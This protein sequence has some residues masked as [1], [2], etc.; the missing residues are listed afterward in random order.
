MLL[1]CYKNK[2]VRLTFMAPASFWRVIWIRC[3][4][5]GQ[6][7]TIY[8]CSRY[9]TFRKN[10][11]LSHARVVRDRFA[12]TETAWTHW[13]RYNAIAGSGWCCQ[14]HYR[15]VGAV[16]Q[17]ISL[18]AALW[19]YSQDPPASDIRLHDMVKETHLAGMIAGVFAHVKA[20]CDRC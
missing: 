9:K 4:P 12:T 11:F 19:L 1:Q 2:R 6:T 14:S 3:N 16:W 13:R 15:G 5:E 10:T 20:S 17:L 8:G 7:R 18:R